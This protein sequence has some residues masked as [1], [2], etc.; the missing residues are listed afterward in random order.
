MPTTLSSTLDGSSTITN[1]ADLDNVIAQANAETA[2]G[3]Y[4]I[5]LGTNATIALTQAL[6]EISLH[7]GVTLDIEGHGATINGESNQRGLFVNAGNV[8]IE[9]LTVIN[10]VALGASGQSGQGE[11]QI[12]GGAG[13]GGGGAGLGG[14]LFVG[15]GAILP[16]CIKAGALGDNV[17]KRD[18]WI[19]PHHAMYLA[20]HG[21]VLV[22]A[23][24]LV[25]GV[26]IVQ[27]KEID[28][29]EYFHIEL[30]T[31]DVIVAEGALS[32]TFLD[33]DDSRSMFNNA[34]E[35]E[36]LYGEQP[37]A[38][39]QYCAPRCQ[40]GY[41]LE[42]IRS[43]I[44]LRTGFAA[45]ESAGTL[46]GHVDGISG[47]FV[48]GW[49]QN[50]DHPDAPVCLDIYV[51]GQLVGQALANRY[52]ED[53]AQAGVGSGHHGFAFRPPAG[54]TLALETIEVRRSLDGAPV[55]GCGKPVGEPQAA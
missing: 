50:A 48:K 44:A 9:N 43:A 7:S 20:E 55:G 5:N 36:M 22:E 10:A 8:T 3:T 15:S 49:A 27:A 11:E 21:G 53:L 14:G 45:T 54:V 38:S 2:S 13:G 30:D 16:V 42:T 6:T 51:E 1:I 25:N 41:E 52:R 32:E 23:K 18:L 31:H 4:V 19:S 17:P 24:D 37:S 28:K 47:G 35:Y 29:V 26:S 46:R 40:G 12:W 39:A 33:E 34:L